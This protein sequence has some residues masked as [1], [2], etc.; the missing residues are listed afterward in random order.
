[1]K[2]EGEI[3][4]DEDDNLIAEM[5][6]REKEDR[7]RT[8][9]R[10]R[11]RG[12][13]RDRFAA[14]VRSGMQRSID[15][16][17]PCVN[18]CVQNTT[19]DESAAKKT[20]LDL[21]V[22][23]DLQTC[24]P[25]VAFHSTHW[26]PPSMALLSQPPSQIVT[27]WLGFNTEN[28]QT[29]GSHK[30]ADGKD[31][32][33]ITISDSD[34]DMSD[35]E[36]LTVELKPDDE[37][38]DELQLRRDALDSAVKYNK[39][40]RKTCMSF[41]EDVNSLL[42]SAFRESGS[43]EL[44]YVSMVP[45]LPDMHHHNK[46][47]QYGV[48]KIV[49]CVDDPGASDG[50]VPFIASSCQIPGTHL[51]EDYFRQDKTNQPGNAVSSNILYSAEFCAIPLPV[52]ACD[53]SIAGL[54]VSE[55]G[56]QAHIDNYD[57][58]EMELDSGS[59]AENPPVSFSEYTPQHLEW[60]ATAADHS[61]PQ[62]QSTSLDSLVST[63]VV[64]SNPAPLMV[65]GFSSDSVVKQCSAPDCS[66]NV[67]VNSQAS[68][69]TTV[70]TARDDKAPALLYV[71]TEMVDS[72][73]SDSI[74]KQRKVEDADKKSELLLRAAVLQSLSSK[75]QQQSQVDT[76]SQASRDSP[77]ISKLQ[78]TSQPIKRT[79]TPSANN[80]LNIKLPVHQPVLITLTEESS[81]SD[82]EETLEVGDHSGASA[83]AARTT[84]DLS[85]ILHEMRKASELQDC[86][87]AATRQAV[88]VSAVKREEEH[89]TGE[90]GL[91]NNCVHS[92]AGLWPMHNEMLLTK[93]PVVSSREGMCVSSQLNAK[94]FQRFELNN[95]KSEIAEEK[96][97]LHQQKVALSK[98]KLKMARKK[99]QIS[100]AE[101]RI[102]KL[103]EQL[104]AAERIAAS[105]KK[106]LHN[107][108][109]E[110]SSLSHGVERH[111]AAVSKLEMELS[112]A[113]KNF[114]NG[115]DLESSIS[116]EIPSPNS[117]LGGCMQG[118][119]A[120]EGTGSC[121]VLSTDFSYFRTGGVSVHSAVS[122]QRSQSV[123]RSSFPSKKPLLHSAS[124][125]PRSDIAS[126]SHSLKNI[127]CPTARGALKSESGMAL[128]NDNLVKRELASEIKVEGSQTVMQIVPHPVKSEPPDISE[129]PT[130]RQG[131]GDSC[132]ITKPHISATKPDML[133][134]Q[135][136]V[137]RSGSNLAVAS[138]NTGSN[139]FSTS[140][141][142][143]VMPSDKK[144]KQ[145]LHHYIS[146]LDKNSCAYSL[147]PSCRL[148][149]SDPVFSFKFP[150]DQTLPLAALPSAGDAESD[151]FRV[152]DCYRPYR[153][154]LL[155]FRSYK[156]SDFFH[157]KGLN[158]L[159]ETFSHKLDCR[160]PLCQ[161]DLMGRCLD[162]SC[163][164]QHRSDYTLSKREQLIDI[165]SYSP[166]V[167]SIDNATP[168]SMYKKLIDEYVDKFTK[169]TCAFSHLD[170]CLRLIDEVRTCSQAVSTSARRWKLRGNR[171]QSSVTD[172]KDLLLSAD[173]VS[174]ICV[175]ES[176]VDYVRYWMVAE[177]DQIKN[178]EEAVSD[179]PSDDSSWIKLA[180][181]K[182]MECKW[183]ASRSE[184]VSY[185][186]NVLTRA[187][188]A[189]PS[190]SRIWTHYL[191][192]YVERSDA[193]CDVSSLYEQAIQ[194]APS[195]KFFWKYL[196]LTV[197]YS[198]KMDICKRL[199]QYLCSPMCCDHADIRSHH[200]LETVL[201]QAALCITSGRFREGLQIIQ[202]IVQSKASVIWLTLTPCD[203][204][205]MWLSFIHL[206]ECRQLPRMLFDPANS[207]PG[208][209]VK[210]EP[211][212]VPFCMGAKTRISYETLLQLFQS[213]LSACDK[214][215]GVG[216]D[217]CDEHSLWLAALRRSR[218]LLEIS[219]YGL[220]GGHRLC[221]ELVKQRPSLVDIWLCLLQLTV[222][223][224]GSASD[225]QAFHSSISSIID[226]AVASNPH[227]VT[228]F[229]ACACALIECG[230]TD[231]ALSFA[232]RCP[233]S[234]YQVEQLDA[235]SVDPNLL[236]CCSLGQPVPPA[237][238][239]PVLWPSVSWQYVANQQ[240]NLWLCYCL[241]LDLQGA[242]DQATQ[243]Y[244]LALTCL[245]GTQD[246]RRLW[247]AFLRRSAAV[248]SQQLPWLSPAAASSDHK[249]T[250]WQQF[251][252][253]V[254]EAL[255]TLPV[256]CSLPHSSQMW[257][258]YSCHNEII[259]LYVSCMSDVG[260]VQDVY[261]KY[262]HKMPGNTELV[263]K[264]VS[265]LLD[266]DL[267]QL[268]H[269][270]CLVALH[271]CPRSAELWNLTLRS[272]Q[273][274]ANVGLMRSLYAKAVTM[275]PFSASLWKMY[276]MFEVV[277]R[278]DEHV[279]E[280]MDKCR[281]LQVNVSSFVENL[282]K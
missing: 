247:L 222:A 133:D 78:V 272:S 117:Q 6:L 245:T 259:L 170:Q 74:Q 280:A 60:T 176:T 94:S 80:Q 267:L 192:L 274:M 26:R 141:N 189:N 223:N 138:T 260:A 99:E 226:K 114:E 1:M 179:S 48:E 91:A 209:V 150:V 144:I 113:Q 252:S 46:F 253:D 217:L 108:T 167:V 251:A 124:S 35:I 161:F 83:A 149:V 188:E 137:G 171:Q 96:R 27:K 148:F 184:S 185:G 271:S 119:N 187:L 275:L 215:T 31:K 69:S 202:A 110:I 109:E 14:T 165:L 11:K 257:D 3:T 118:M 101:K 279:K 16:Q 244:H 231:T 177:S 134:E 197:S 89:S 190:N 51:L 268:C 238:K 19:D 72:G 183:S 53:N 20:K 250:L 43:T 123:S 219:R 73:T 57:E 7:R 120:S 227:S 203:R 122:S 2:E 116:S 160:V 182:M 198:Q 282:L 39:N 276:I 151:S 228:L 34:I 23:P 264:T 62:S 66:H 45:N 22:R 50:V 126:M 277:N 140:L 82:N 262:V 129:Q 152:G 15:S 200:L 93:N 13:G 281:C 67:A 180:Y 210:K 225:D 36:V 159:S 193:D 25:P 194:Y 32:E 75:R 58:V 59:D 64:D 146:S 214:D 97:K 10:T 33:I 153:S 248:I 55:A 30:V 98:A 229:L 199:R 130:V 237:Y 143:F 125:V 5:A 92:G 258:D 278:S 236:Y 112:V 145:V 12:S 4:D 100:S 204:I 191:D 132:L 88:A 76:V 265:H 156:H 172:T 232:E 168:I 81:D 174:E 135:K 63:S 85:R 18:G 235:S 84:D 254:D 242:H 241:L 239:R 243:T 70:C 90:R 17:K 86:D 256:R 263:L 246:I 273:R 21:K 249:L 201:Y 37:D 28:S 233:I 164:W 173:G 166:S 104:V 131:A 79:V 269:G 65:A 105:S 234:L 115:V 206:Y 240:A 24:V 155:C 220:L 42:S 154:S 224:K 157:Q 175:P 270:L 136:T 195:Y 207:N 128:L 212:V 261:E 178:L 230:D 68:D 255:S 38:L 196:Q 211:F 47:V 77:V 103:R 266:Q 8:S 162:D 147:A 41:D 181:A 213:A 102:R 139:V 71:K 40:E 9:N 163:P 121:H 205:V 29:S 221:E 127:R 49:S 218:I 56:Q 44:C 158:V 52:S 95:L 186:L 142:E 106:L 111:Q 87:I 107:L 61:L 216:S 208:P 54:P 169:E